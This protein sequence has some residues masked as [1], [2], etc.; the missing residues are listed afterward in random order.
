MIRSIVLF[1]A[2][3]GILSSNAI[4]ET[5]TIATYNLNWGN[6]R[7]DQ[8]LD[9]ISEADSDLICFQETTPVT[10]RSEDRLHFSYAAL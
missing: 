3:V 1:I 8:I 9:A 10:A 5:F 4:G 6:R 2:S 7:G